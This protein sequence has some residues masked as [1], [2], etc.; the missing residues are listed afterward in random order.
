VPKK[1]VHVVPSGGKWVVKK[2]GSAKATS[3]HKTQSTAWKKGQSV[4][5]TEKTEAYLHGRDG[6]I[7]ERNTYGNDPR[8]SKG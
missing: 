2:E 1:A 5:R 6:R 4:A 3:S 8:K 7:R